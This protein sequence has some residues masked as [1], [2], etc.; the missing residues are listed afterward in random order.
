MDS[1]RLGH[2]SYD[3]L[4]DLCT[5]HG[6]HRKNSKEALEPRAQEVREANDIPSTGAG[7]RGPPPE[8]VV[9]QLQSQTFAPNTRGGGEALRAASVPDKE[10][11]TGLAQ[12]R[13]PG[14][15]PRVAASRSPAVDGVEAAISA[16]VPGHEL[17]EGGDGAHADLVRAA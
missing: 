16:W 5:R 17:P 6:R 15:K 14:W 7:K 3:Q 4:H 10:V 1:G 11:V 9:D 2:V 8:Y 12:W 13:N